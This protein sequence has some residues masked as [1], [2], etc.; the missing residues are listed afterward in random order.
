MS[1]FDA[2]QRVN[3]DHPCPA[4]GKA[5]WCAFSSDGRFIH[6]QRS[7]EWNGRRAIRQTA[8]GWLHAM[9]ERSPQRIP[10][11]LSLSK[12]GVRP[13]PER[14]VLDAVYRRLADLCGLDDHARQDLI[15]ARHFPEALDGDAVYFSLPAAGNS[16]EAIS[17]AL[18][19]EFGAGVI[20]RVPGFSVAC[21]SCNGSAGGRGCQECGGLGRTPP[22]FRS[23]RGGRH[24]YG[25]IACDEDG[26]A[27]WGCSRTLP[28]NSDSKSPKYIL[29]S[30]SRSL[31][32]SL[33]G[34]PKYHVAGRQYPVGDE[35]WIS[36]GIVKTEILSRRLQ[37]R[38]IGIYSTSVDGPTLAEVR[39]LVGEWR[40]AH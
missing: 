2:R 20:E 12:P 28:F 30:S 14:L 1:R 18:V 19:D 33:A 5:D 6:C 32:P 26:L 35:V 27:F 7:E 36:E 17:G 16:N 11:V 4:C 24:D 22:R 3:R 21:K 39:R 38:A 23:V 13:T 15:N 25:L 29:L 8:A 34:Q 31:D 10:P 9:D 40:C 37:R